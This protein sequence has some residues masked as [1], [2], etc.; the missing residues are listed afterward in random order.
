MVAFP[1]SS[2]LPNIAYSF[3]ASA[4]GNDTGAGDRVGVGVDE[5]AAD[6]TTG[7]GV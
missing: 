5:V 6:V 2:P 1:C 4:S 3:I 7:T